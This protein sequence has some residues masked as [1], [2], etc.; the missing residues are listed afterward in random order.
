MSR[1]AC[2]DKVDYFHFWTRP[3]EAKPRMFWN[4]AYLDWRNLDTGLAGGTEKHTG[5][6]VSLRWDDDAEH[7][8]L[9]KTED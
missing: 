2:T 7:W 1:E 8:R 4:T 6:P 3:G 5:E 9:T